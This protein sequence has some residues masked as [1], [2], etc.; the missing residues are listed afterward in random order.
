VK[1]V[2]TSKKLL[3]GRSGLAK[4]YIM[5]SLE[6]SVDVNDFCTVCS[7]N[8]HYKEDITKRIAILS[9]NSSEVIGW[10][11]PNCFTEFDMEDN[12]KVL[13]SKSAIQAEG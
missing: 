9:D 5:S 13:M 4:E 10:C 8:L 3:F 2:K 6:D 11:C 1:L 12:I 7:E